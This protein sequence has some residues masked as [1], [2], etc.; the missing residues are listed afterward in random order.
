MMVDCDMHLFEPRTLWADYLST[1]EAD[2]A[3]SIEDDDLG[4]PW[5]CW[6]GQ[7][8][9]LAEPHSPGR[10]D[11]VGAY[12]RRQRERLPPALDGGSYDEMVA[13]Y[14]DPRRRLDHLRQTG[15]EGAVLFPNYGIIWE[16][17]LHDDLA[18]TRLNMRAWNRWAVEVAAEGAGRLFPVAHLTLRGEREWLLSELAALAKGGIRLALI[19]PAL[20]DGRPLSAPDLD[21]VWA[22]FVD[23]GVTPVFH[24]ANQPR[25]FDDA[26]Y[27]NEPDAALS[28]ISSVFLWT[29]PALAT[30]DM[31]LNGVF[32]RHPDLRLGIMELSAVWVPMHLMMMDG[33]FDFTSKFNGTPI[34]ALADRPSGY[35]RRHIRVAAFSYERPD[36]LRRKAGDIF[37][38]CSDWPHTEGTATPLADYEAVQLTPEADR[39]FFG[40][41]VELLLGSLP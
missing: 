14:S 29:A 12:R 34:T 9:S 10:T 15:F 13:G 17:A 4:Y 19:P 5:L 37:M 38:A 39:G 18:A 36:A 7:R 28:V 26:W 11:A 20:V 25:P 24:V 22:A 1:G 31:I 2:L 40:G 41:N 32:D 6:Q 23:H 3:V 35:F 21:W 16:R 33:G 8:L 27:G 30:T